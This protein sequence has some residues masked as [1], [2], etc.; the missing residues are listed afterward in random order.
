MTNLKQ[1]TIHTTR[2]EPLSCPVY[3]SYRYTDPVAASI[4]LD[5]LGLPTDLRRKTEHLVHGKGRQRFLEADIGPLHV[6]VTVK[7]IQL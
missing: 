7:Q 3:Q 4:A 6:E 2:T 1:V 5:R